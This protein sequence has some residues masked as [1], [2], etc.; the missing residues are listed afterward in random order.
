MYVLGYPC[1]MFNTEHAE[2]VTQTS[3]VGDIREFH[4]IS[5]AME[6]V[7]AV[8][9][10]ASLIDISMFPDVE[11]LEATNVLGKPS[12]NRKWHTYT[13]IIGFN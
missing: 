9:H 13:G 3:I 1:F 11:R 7:D 8:I 5:E 2:N 4:D 6:G 12:T 10:A